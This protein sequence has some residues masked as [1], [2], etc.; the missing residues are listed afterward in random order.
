MM[1]D[2]FNLLT[3]LSRPSSVSFYPVFILYVILASSRKGCVQND[4]M[5]L[6]GRILKSILFKHADAGSLG[7]SFLFYFLKLCSPI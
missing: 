7:C 5:I 2:L 6:V 3:P 4:L 1:I